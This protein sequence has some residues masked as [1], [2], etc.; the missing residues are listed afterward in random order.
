MDALA[1]LAT[2]VTA[3]AKKSNS[4]WP[5]VTMPFF[6]VNAHHARKA[7][8]IEVLAMCPLV[9]GGVREQWEQYSLQ[10][11]GWI[12]ESRG[13]VLD[14]EDGLDVT[15][16]GDASI[17]PFVFELDYSAESPFPVPVDPSRDVSQ[18]CGTVSLCWVT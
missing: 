5:F 18:S 4:E 12:E 17:L 2:E 14:D 7:S 11:A 1:G 3:H 16:Y 13:I 8:G 15:N 6:E 9:Q 10:N